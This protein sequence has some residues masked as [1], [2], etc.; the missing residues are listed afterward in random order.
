[1]AARMNPEEIKKL[2]K[3][4]YKG[5]PA[6]VAMMNRMGGD[7]KVYTSTVQISRVTPEDMEAISADKDIGDPHFVPVIAVEPEE[8]KGLR[9]VSAIWKGSIFSKSYNVLLRSYR[10]PGY[11]ELD[12]V[13]HNNTRWVSVTGWLLACEGD[14][15]DKGEDFTFQDLYGWMN[16]VKRL[17]PYKVMKAFLPFVGLGADNAEWWKIANVRHLTVEAE[18]EACQ[19]T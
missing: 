9:I 5:P 8:D 2:Q 17:A 19:K 16:R 1:M 15:I 4:T 11:D 6:K 12:R 18:E 14:R 13:D 7:G 10:L 3:F